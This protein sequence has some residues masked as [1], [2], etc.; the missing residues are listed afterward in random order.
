MKPS[1]YITKGW[2]QGEFARDSQ[3]EKCYL[4]SPAVSEWCLVGAIKE[5]Y[6]QDNKK[7]RRAITKLQRKLNS[8]QFA[9]WNDDPTRTQAEV[10]ALL[11]SIGE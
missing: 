2:C 10:V 11:Q 1:E 3:G 6:L 9:T 8:L 7:C 4:Y 5:A